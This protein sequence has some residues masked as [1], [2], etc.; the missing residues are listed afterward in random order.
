MFRKT[1]EWKNIQI[2]L[3]DFDNLTNIN[4]NI[5]ILMVLLWKD[6]TEKLTFVYSD[7]TFQLASTYC[8]GNKSFYHAVALSSCFIHMVLR[9]GKKSGFL[10][11]GVSFSEE[12]RSLGLTSE[13][14][15]NAWDT[16][17]PPRSCF[18]CFSHFCMMC[19]NITDWKEHGLI[20]T[21]ETD[22]GKRSYG[23]VPMLTDDAPLS[24]S[25]QV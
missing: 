20:F 22:S 16:S 7:V 4:I 1:P 9:V 6:F 19:A 21:G 13:C 11:T 5:V 23:K 2:Y 17:S 15:S 3:S 14:N 24:G 25:Q 18:W 12:K 8:N 10:K